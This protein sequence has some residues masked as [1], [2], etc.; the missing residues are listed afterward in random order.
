MRSLYYSLYILLTIGCLSC[1]PRIPVL[2]PSF[3]H[4]AILVEDLAVSARFYRDVVGLPEIYDGT[5]KDN[6]RWFDLGNGS[7][8]HIIQADRSAI[9]TAKPVHLCMS[10]S[11]FD[12][13]VESLRTNGV[14]FEDWPGNPMVSNVRPDGVRQVYFQDPDGYWLELNDARNFRKQFAKL[15]RPAAND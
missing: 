13:Y 10:V 3:D 15:P 14:D 11:N 4:Y 2:Q 5:E 12:G 8:L 1:S 7:A 6:I 9:A